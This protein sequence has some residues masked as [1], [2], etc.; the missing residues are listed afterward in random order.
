MSALAPVI[1]IERRDWRATFARAKELGGADLILTDPPYWTLNRWR[2]IGTTTR[3]GGHREADKRDEAAWFATIDHDEL[4]EFLCDSW[5]ALRPNRH[6]YIMSDGATLPY[7]LGFAVHPM[8]GQPAWSN[9][10]P[11]VWD[12]VT[13]GMGYH[14]RARHEFVVM[15]DKGRRRLNDLGRP[16]I[17]THAKIRG[18]YPTEKPV[19]LMRELLENSSNP[20]EL[21][22]DPF[23]GSG[24]VA[25]ACA[26]TG[27]RFVGGD[28]EERAVVL[29]RGRALASG[30]RLL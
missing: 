8:E 2:E 4:W 19:A 29:A 26:E 24:A 25:V 9:V 14:W 11:L 3:L 1:E 23:C 5:I 28:I 22:C 21:V 20:G 16:D 12:K 30:H 10:K 13:Q 18:G 17:L 15:L 7:L 6:A 27:R